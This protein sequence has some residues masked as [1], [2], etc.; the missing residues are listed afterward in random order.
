M[1]RDRERPTPSTR[2][3][4]SASRPLRPD[5]RIR[6]DRRPAPPP[7]PMP[8]APS[9]YSLSDLRDWPAASANE[10]RPARLAVLGDPVAHS[11][12]PQMHNP[13]LAA[14]GIDAS[15]VRIHLTPDELE[16]GVALMKEADFIGFNVTVPHKAAMHG[17][18]DEATEEAGRAGAVNTVLIEDGQLLGHNT[19][20]P[21]F[22][23]AVREVFSMDLTD[24]RILV[25]GAGG[26]AG[27]AVAAQAAMEHCER[28]VLV[29]RTP[30]KAQALAAAL[31]SVIHDPDKLEG[32]A[33]QLVAIPWEERAIEREIDQIDLIVNATS[34][35]MK[36]TDP[37][38]LPERFLQPHHLVYD[39][40]YSPAR[41]RLMAT[42]E[43]A[44]ARAVNGLGMLL[45]QGVYAF[46]FWFDGSAPVEAMRQGLHG[47]L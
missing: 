13:A 21:G 16:E 11:R 44:G 32:P 12:S 31:R 3:P 29:N 7:L 41:T 22:K 39:M 4:P 40:V 1:L 20:G 17:L 34:L 28:L 24:L 42:A 6:P 2:I 25:L 36:R 43:A 35:G 15:Y 9:H 23:R 37:A 10:E 14:T 30:E 8:D 33:G 38:L 46:E 26:G 47:S 5:F 27:Q 18:V 45:W 19:D